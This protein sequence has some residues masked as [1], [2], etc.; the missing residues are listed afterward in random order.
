MTTVVTSGLAVK[1]PNCAA[2]LDLSPDTVVYVCRYCG[3]SGFVTNEKVSISG[4][5]PQDLNAV[6]ASVESFLRRRTGGDFAITEQKLIMAPFWLT[7]AHGHTRYNGYRSES[8]SAAI[9]SGKDQRTEVYTVYRPVK[10][11]IDEDLVLTLFARRHER[12]FAL[13]KAEDA[14]RASTPSQ[15]TPDQLMLLAKVAE[16]LTSSVG[17]DEASHWAET[18]VGDL[19][20]ARVEGMCTKVFECYTDVVIQSNQL[21][22]YPL[23]SVRFEERGSTFRMLYD[24]AQAKVL[25]AEVPLTKAQR[26]GFLLAG[27]GASAALAGASYAIGAQAASGAIGISA[28][29]AFTAFGF[30]AYTTLMATRSQRQ[31]GES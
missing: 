29:L 30:A 3:W 2:S 5:V 14:V 22:L 1:C 9:G 6:K 24:A 8:R 27:Y 12:I 18:K 7:K 15:L 28:V 21:V 17:V 23:Y 19:H 10:G 31:L 25:E 26:A 4:V 16:F 20:R 11:V 13:E